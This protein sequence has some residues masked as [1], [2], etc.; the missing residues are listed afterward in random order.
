[1]GAR[2]ARA[3]IGQACLLAGVMWGATSA[4]HAQP[5]GPP[6]PPFA[7]G[8]YAETFWQWNFNRP[9]NGITNYRGFD[10]R[11][12]AF[13]L[14]NVAVDL[15]ADAADVVARLTLQIGHTPS[16]YYLSEPRSDGTAGANESDASL[17]KYLQ[18]AWVGY[19]FHPWG[20]PLV[21]SAGLFLSPI[22]PESMAVRE[23]WT[24]SRSNLFFGLPFYHTGVRLTLAVTDAWSVT[25]AGYNGWNSVVDNNR[26]KSLALSAVYAPSDALQLGLLYFGGCERPEDA[27]EGQPWRHTVDAHVTWQISERWGVIGHL[28]YGLESNDVGTSWWAAGQALGRLALH[29]TLSF[30]LRGDLFREH[31]ATNGGRSAS[32]I[33]WP[34]A[35]VTSTT[36]TLDYHPDPHVSFRL[37]F[38]HDHAES[39]MYY[40]GQVADAAVPDADRQ[41]TLTVG[42][43]AGF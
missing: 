8:G 37:E 11:H 17:W 18:Q 30:A 22:G 12:N 6:T 4:A 23:N 5:S 31:V 7:L 19:R 41:S 35:W 32:A 36:L 29:D 3:Q 20:R 33:F 25:L 9:D 43:T 38:R 13:T 21:L 1:M 42:A 34:S 28:D 24:W 40:R 39:R 27:P 16:T 14:A 26:D 15:Q 10:N 2:A